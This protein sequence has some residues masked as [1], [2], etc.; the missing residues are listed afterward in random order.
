MSKVDEQTFD[1]TVIQFSSNLKNRRDIKAFMYI[2]GFKDCIIIKVGAQYSRTYS[3]IVADENIPYQ[4][5]TNSKALYRIKPS[6]LKS[7]LR[8]CGLLI[9][10]SNPSVEDELEYL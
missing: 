7:E 9:N 6:D 4:L 10:N 5:F 3:I 2:L 1:K 8:R